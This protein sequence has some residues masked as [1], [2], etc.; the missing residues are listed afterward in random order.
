MLTAARLRELLSYDPDTGVFRWRVSRP[1]TRGIGSIAGA[2]DGQGY[3][4]IGIDGRIYRDH[5]L[6]WLYMTGEWPADDVDHINRDRGDCRFANLR[7]ATRSQNNANAKRPSDNTSGYKGVSFDKR[8]GRWHA[9]I[10]HGGR[11]KNLGM[12]D[13]AVA[14]YEARLAA[15][16]R[17]HGEFARAA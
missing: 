4:Q 6:A 12:F 10:S 7:E 14:A 9:Y 3:H 17:L 8:R 15:A 5:R 2:S 16:A 1:G 11:R 13:T